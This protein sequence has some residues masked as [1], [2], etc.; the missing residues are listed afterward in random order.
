M[1]LYDEAMLHLSRRC[2]VGFERFTTTLL[3]TRRGSEGAAAR[4]SKQSREI[5][6]SESLHQERRVNFA[7]ALDLQ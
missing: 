3:Q 4:N 6:S 2:R 7:M 5:G 1:G